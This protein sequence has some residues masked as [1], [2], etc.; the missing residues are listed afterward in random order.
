MIQSTW[1]ALG[2]ALLRDF[3]MAK[4]AEQVQFATENIA[5]HFELSFDI[6]VDDNKVWLEVEAAY[7]NL[8][9]GPNPPL[10]PPFAS[11]Y[12]EA[13][14]T[15]GARSSEMRA[16]FQQLGYGLTLQGSVPEDHVA[17]IFDGVTVLYALSEDL[18]SNSFRKNFLQK[19]M[20]VWL[21]Q[22]TANIKK[23]DEE[24]RPIYMVAQATE[25]WLN[26]ALYSIYSDAL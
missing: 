4:S 8:F 18:A 23:Q 9:V 11:Q 13:T 25:K 15:I 21:L 17:Y 22:F 24:G 5:R 14:A 1:I 26:A 2:A 3:Y 20:E 6:S 7:N 19:H 10:C 16:L 12:L